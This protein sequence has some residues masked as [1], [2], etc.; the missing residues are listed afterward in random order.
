MFQIAPR[1][2]AIRR[3]GDKEFSRECRGERL[4]GGKVVVDEE[5]P[6]HEAVKVGQSM[7]GALAHVAYPAVAY[8]VTPGRHMESS[9]VE[10]LRPRR[11]HGVLRA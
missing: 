11:C 7:E 2:S 8:E 3:G 5:N 6:F 9:T 10:S 4:Q 1:R